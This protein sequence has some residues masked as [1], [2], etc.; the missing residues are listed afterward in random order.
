MKVTGVGG[1]PRDGVGAVALNVTVTETSAPSFLTVSP[2]GFRRPTASN[3]NWDSARVTKANAVIVKVGSRGMIDLYNLAGSTHAIVDVAG[4]FREG[5]GFHPVVPDRVLDTRLGGG[6]PVAGPG[7]VDLGLAASAVPTGADGVVFNLTST[8]ASEPSF[9]VAYPAGEDRPGSSHLNNFPGAT[10]SNLVVS[11]LRSSDDVTLFNRYG[12]THLVA[13][14]AGWFV[15]GSGYTGIVPR[16]ILDTRAARPLGAGSTMSVPIHGQLAGVPAT[17][18]V[19]IL[20]VTAVLP[21]EPSFLTVFPTG[22][23][24]PRASNVNFEPGMVVPNLVVA[25]I[26]A[27]G[28]IDIGNAHGEVD[29]VVD[30]LGYLT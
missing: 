19:A 2:H 8:E 14:V 11:A 23:A 21:T 29:V 30:L 27:G 22:E 26:G 25:T 5:G 24:W 17:A 12:S 7:H 18:Q 13:D 4:W 10:T 28:S 20:N 3:L 9:V 15:A 1:V 16:R 6:A